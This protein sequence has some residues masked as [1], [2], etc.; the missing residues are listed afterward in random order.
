MKKSISVSELNFY[1][2]NL[3][4]TDLF[5]QDIWVL[6]E[7]TNLKHYRIGGQIYFNL[8]DGE[9]RINCVVYENFWQNMK[10]EPREGSKVVARGK[11]RLFQKK[12][13]YIFQV[14]FMMKEGE[15]AVNQQFEELKKKLYQEGLFAEERKQALPL[16]PL[17]VGLITAADSAAMWDFWTIVQDVAPNIKC[18]LIPAVMQGKDC[19]GSVIKALDLVQQYHKLDL[20]I[21]LRGGGDPQDLA[22][23]NDEALVRY[24]AGFK[25]PV[26]A[27]IGHEVDYSLVDLVADL[28]L[29]TPTAAAQYLVSNYQN[30]ERNA[31]EYLN[32]LTEKIEFKMKEIENIIKEIYTKS[33]RVL[34]GQQENAKMRLN[35]LLKRLENVDPLH[36]LQQGY[37]ISKIFETGEIIKSVKQIKGGQL[38]Q[39]KLYDGE[40]KSVVEKDDGI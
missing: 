27:A 34:D 20:V 14:F 18:V 16:Y 40:F 9:S 4:E 19:P 3:L 15:G 39:T 36:K 31:K 30:L 32:L 37:G 38:L 11:L 7:I 17:K 2:K 22:G 21:I 6:G 25:L 24:I 5:L 28:R 1:I 35:Y 29:P 13:T 10:F 23:F 26:V 8:T 12:G 33:K